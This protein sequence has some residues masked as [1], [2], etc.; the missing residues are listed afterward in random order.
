MLKC[1]SVGIVTK[2]VRTAFGLF[3]PR[4]CFALVMLNVLHAASGSGAADLSQIQQQRVGVSSPAMMSSALVSGY[5]FDFVRSILVLDARGVL[6]QYAS[7]GEGV[8][9]L[10]PLSGSVSSKSSRMCHQ[11]LHNTGAPVTVSHA[12]IEN[13]N[14]CHLLSTV[15]RVVSGD[16]LLAQMPQRAECQQQDHGSIAADG[17]GFVVLGDMNS[18]LRKQYVSINGTDIFV[19]SQV[20]RFQLDA[21]S[22]AALSDDDVLDAGR[23]LLPF[24]EV[25]RFDTTAAAVNREE[26]FAWNVTTSKF[27]VLRGGGKTGQNFAVRG[28]AKNRDS[29]ELQV[30]PH[31]KEDVLECHD[32]LLLWSSL[33]QFVKDSSVAC[34]AVQRSAVIPIA[35]ILRDCQQ[36]AERAPQATSAVSIAASS[37]DAAAGYVA[38]PHGSATQDVHVLDLLSDTSRVVA[39]GSNGAAVATDSVPVSATLLGAKSTHLRAPAAASRSNS[40]ALITE[41]PLE[42]YRNAASSVARGDADGGVSLTIQ[43]SWSRHQI[44]VVC[45]V[46]ALIATAIFA[47]VGIFPRRK[48]LAAWEEVDAVTQNWHRHDVPSSA[49]P[50]APPSTRLGP[51][52]PPPHLDL[53]AA[54]HPYVPSSSL[55]SIAARACDVS[56]DVA[57]GVSP[58]ILP[59]ASTAHPLPELV[60]MPT[61]TTFLSADIGAEQLCAPLIVTRVPLKPLP[62]DHLALAT[63]A[64]GTTLIAVAAQVDGSIIISPSQSTMQKTASSI[65]SKPSTPSLDAGAAVL[66]PPASACSNLSFRSNSSNNN[67][68]KMQ[69]VAAGAEGDVLVNS[70]FHD[71]ATET[72]VSQTDVGDINVNFSNSSPASPMRRANLSQLEDARRYH[73]EEDVAAHAEDESSTTESSPPS[74]TRTDDEDA[75]EVE[76]SSKSMMSPGSDGSN[77]RRFEELVATRSECSDDDDWWRRGLS[78]AGIS[79]NQQALIE[80]NPKRASTLREV[81]S[82]VGSVGNLSG[83]EGAVWSQPTSPTV[84]GTGAPLLL[85]HS[86]T[87]SPGA[88]HRHGDRDDS[89]PD[90]SQ[91][92]SSRRAHSSLAAPQL[93]QQHF[94]VQRR[95][96]FG[97]AGSVFCVENRVTKTQYAIKVVPLHEDDERS[98]R[99]A[100]LHSSFDCP[101]VVRFFYCW[102]EDM[103]TDDA[104]RLGIFDKDDGLDAMSDV[105]AAA[106]DFQLGRNPHL[107]ATSVTTSTSVTTGNNNRLLFMQMEYFKCGTL[108]DWLKKR[109]KKL[110]SQRASQQTT[111]CVAQDGDAGP[112]PTVDIDRAEACDYL[113]H[114]CKGLEYLHTQGIVHRDIKPSN[115]FLTEKNTVKIGDFGLACKE[116]TARHASTYDSLPE[117][118]LDEQTVSGCSPLYCSPEQREGRR[119]TPASD[120]FSV[121]VLAVELFACFTTAHE[122]ISTLDSLRARGMP[123]DPLMDAFPDEMSLVAAMLA[124]Q[125]ASRPSIASVITRLKSLV[126]TLKL[127][128]RRVGSN[129]TPTDGSSIHPQSMGLFS[130][131]SGD[132]LPSPSSPDKLPAVPPRDMDTEQMPHVTLSPSS[133]QYFHS[134]RIAAVETALEVPPPPT[135]GFD[136][137][138]QDAQSRQNSMSS[139]SNYDNEE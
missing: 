122:R 136:R 93:F 83:M 58:M 50:S 12:R 125:P 34:F 86:M 116:R 67:S 118:G 35:D 123:P 72:D 60:M 101:Y 71:A 126:R 32:A 14:S 88:T 110:M 77:A 82:L 108:E 31:H 36:N 119:V 4:F 62:L 65:E 121:G 73:E 33:P 51:L 128:K 114:I 120:I 8:N 29:A 127:Q 54:H 10:S 9:D 23:V 27:R 22:G 3:A 133:S 111:G 107:T 17:G 112:K 56:N 115:V 131:G 74:G 1:A 104:V 19:T 26:S 45:Q 68:N 109:Q 39:A 16:V 55:L 80:N 106:H 20:S 21:S 129:G 24:F 11:W 105:S 117:L 52:S 40:V 37:L 134:G 137:D 47:G 76:A 103:S 81:A 87:S 91:H 42:E 25:V 79:R 138:K 85:V 102:I 2:T 89:E 44:Y 43:L 5:R 41:D 66:W 92:A 18:L 130:G 84:G 98:I 96:G 90:S 70:S 30:H 139:L 15:P 7:C 64:A 6:H 46:A 113:L 59:Q 69:H 124:I 100:V 28:S 132:V 135:F 95:I 38:H 57:G 48:F 75:D 49:A 61:A 13:P 97:G 63:A 78:A 53:A 99:E 94:K